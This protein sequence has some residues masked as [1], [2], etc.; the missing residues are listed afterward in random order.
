MFIEICLVQRFAFYLG[1]PAYSIATIHG[2]LL[3]SSGA[4]AAVFQ[5]RPWPVRRVIVLAAVLIAME[6]NFSTVL[7][8]AA[9]LYLLAGLTI[10]AFPPE[11]DGPR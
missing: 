8:T 5:G 2:G 11:G 6:M 4:G 3:I 1:N 7:V 10:R 9:G